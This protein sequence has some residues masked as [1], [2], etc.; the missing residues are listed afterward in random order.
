MKSILKIMIV[1]AGC[2]GWLSERMASYLLRRLG[3]V[4][5]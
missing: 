2:R 1:A 5:V 3:L 4:N